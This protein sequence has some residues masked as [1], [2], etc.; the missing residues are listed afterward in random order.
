MDNESFVNNNLTLLKMKVFCSLIFLFF[1]VP[2][3]SQ[4][5]KQKNDLAAEKTIYLFNARLTDSLYA[6]TSEEFKKAVSY[7]LLKDVLT[8][9]L[10]PLGKIRKIIP[11]KFESGISKYKAVLDSGNLTMLLGANSQGMLTAFGFQP[12]KPEFSDT[13]A[14]TKSDNL[15]KNML[16]KK[17]DSIIQPLMY[18]GKITGM[19]IG[20]IHKGKLY[21]YNY[22]ETKKGNGELPNANSIYEIGSITKTFTGLLLANAVVDGKMKL[23]DPVNNYL[24]AD[25]PI[26]KQGTDTMRVVH[27]ANHT[28]GLA[29]IPISILYGDRLNPY[30]TFDNQQLYNLLRGV[31]LLSKPGE[32]LSYS[33]LGVGLLGVLLENV[34]HEP[35]EVLVKQLIL[36]KAGMTS[37]MQTLDSVSGK[38]LLQGYDANGKENG[39]WDFKALAGAGALR[40]NVKDMLVYAQYQLKENTKDTLQKKILKLS[41]TKTYQK[42]NQQIALN[43]FIKTTGKNSLFFHDGQTGGYKSFLAFN[44]TTQNAVVILSNTAVSNDEEGYRLMNFLDTI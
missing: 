21:Y 28:S 23:L 11:E 14:M 10:Y 32:V 16:D 1:F 9:N 5:L 4:V 37:T 8:K 6:L 36:D 19:S 38:N 27:L 40:S 7:P 43:W 35:Y 41:H 26:L 3:Y 42:N 29:R 17:V 22:G 25:I 33:N 12:Y 44:L 31:K 39:P 20:L 2:S 34:Y 30:N 13:L 24:P 15:L 18:A